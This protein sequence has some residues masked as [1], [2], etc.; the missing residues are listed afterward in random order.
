[1]ADN[2]DLTPMN[3]KDMSFDD[4]L[5]CAR[6]CDQIEKFDWMLMYV[7]EILNKDQMLGFDERNL[8]S[9][10]FKNYIGPE[11]TSWRI[12]ESVL[13]RER[14]KN[15]LALTE[16]QIGH[17]Q[18]IKRDCE[19]RVEKTCLEIIDKIEKKMM[20]KEESPLATI[21]YLKMK[22]DYYRYMAEF[23]VETINV[24]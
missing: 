2:L 6:I 10:A 20:P 16:S 5:Y 21:F 7:N 18:R 23:Q 17:V 22:G 9:V 1:M 3:L 4:L 24:Q 19:K 12:C 15:A 8:V 13:K 11:R 14:G